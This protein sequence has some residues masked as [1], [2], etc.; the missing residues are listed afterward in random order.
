MRE[1]VLEEDVPVVEEELLLADTE[2]A[3]HQGIKSLG[4]KTVSR[5]VTAACAQNSRM[6]QRNR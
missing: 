4:R 1:A 3:C 6:I 2:Q 5:I